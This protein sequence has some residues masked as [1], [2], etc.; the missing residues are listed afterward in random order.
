MTNYA[1]LTH[2][3]TQP[4]TTQDCMQNILKLNDIDT[5]MM[6]SA[7]WTSVIIRS[8]VDAR[9]CRISSYNNKCIL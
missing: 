3:H 7:V 2:T 1:L 6:P 8:P 9:R 4:A 5:V